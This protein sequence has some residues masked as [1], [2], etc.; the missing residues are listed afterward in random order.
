MPVPPII[1]VPPEHLTLIAGE[2]F[3][4]ECDADGFPTPQISWQR[5]GQPISIGQRIS[6]EADN[7][8]LI[9]EHT[10]ESDAGEF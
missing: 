5:D 9:V 6:F 8:E 4:L 7:T 10:K 2:S 1:T 3:T